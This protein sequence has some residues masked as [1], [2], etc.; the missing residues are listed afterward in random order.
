MR[1]TLLPLLLALIL[2]PSLT[3]QRTFATLDEALS[4]GA[5]Y[6]GASGPQNIQW[7]DGGARYSY[8]LFNREANRVEIR[9][10]DPATG[11][12]RLVFDGQGLT[13][14]GTGEAFGFDSFQW[15]SDSK[16]LLFQSNF[17]PIYRRSGISDYYQYRL[18]DAQLQLVAKDAGT[19]ER[20]PDGRHVG[21][22]RGG[23]LYLYSFAT[24]QETRLTH[25]A[26]ESRFNGRFGWVY[27]EE[28]GLAQ[29][30]SWSHDSRHIAF[31][32]EDESEVP[33]FRMTDYAGPGHPEYVTL[34]YP[35][36][37]DTNPTMRIGVADITTGEVRFMETGE[38]PDSYIP[39]IY[40]TSV[41]GQLAVQWMNREQTHIKLYFFDVA[42]GAR[43]LVMEERSP[44]WIDV[45]N[46]FE[47]IDHHI[48]FPTCSQDFFWISDRDGFRHVYH[49]DY[50][51]K[52]LRQVTSGNWDVTNLYAYDA[53]SKQLFYASTEASPL[54]RH[55]YVIGTNGRDKRRLTTEAGRHT[56]DMG[57]SAA[58]FIDR[59]SNVDTPPQ[60]LLK[61]RR[62]R[63]LRVLEDNAA[64][65]RNLETVAYSPR[66]LHRFTTEEGHA[67][68]ALVIYPLGFDS[69]K[70]YPMVL[71][72][73]GGPGSQ[74]VF[75][76]WESNTWR[77][78]LAQRGYVVV[79]VNNRGSSGYGRDFEKQVY[80]NL[81]ELEARDFHL[82]ARYFGSKPWV[83]AGRIAIRGHSYGGYMALYAMTSHPETFQVGI[84]AAPVS[85]WRLYD[86]IYT[87]RYM[88]LVKANEAG[89][90]KSSPTTRASQLRGKLLLVHSSMDENVHVQHTFQ[91]AKALI[92][93]RI[94]HDLRIFPPGA[95]GVSYNRASYLYLM[96]LYQD[97]LDG[98]L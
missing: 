12:D 51:G 55:L 77:Q 75:N 44:V 31:W 1:R 34:K 96:N 10:H 89:Y 5:L 74:S 15:T 61:D 56:I 53:R 66:R 23:E 18:A 49:Y 36:V 43:R 98:N 57:P 93:H 29:A 59:Y 20:S 14:P 52:L 19:A 50:T 62:G 25:D 80:L 32:Q 28:F 48:F 73:Y 16:N 83:D 45:Y 9:S 70:A 65:K 8:V 58:Y 35:K 22:E 38:D 26:T 76:Q 41:P 87:E 69:T 92:D 47:R 13:F 39:R 30:W 94:D 2:A 46:F 42:T 33:L 85:D 21:F 91:F 24:G 95:H 27:E 86:T 11:A 72:I 90:V 67:L 64:V 7:F 78:F 97:F 4:S 81:G 40:W 6:S 68:D 84:S 71:D 3:A 88:G 17:R 54:E 79:S 63:T 60:V 37:G 82:T